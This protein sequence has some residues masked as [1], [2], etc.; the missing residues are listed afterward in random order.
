MN[1]LWMQ[2]I[3]SFE[4]I[5]QDASSRRLFLKM[6]EMSKAGTIGNF[7]AHLADDDEVDEDTKG[8]VA[9]IAQDHAFLLA[10]EDYLQRTHRIH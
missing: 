9:E 1:G 2:D 7:L 5:C 10:V 4:Q 8:S 3:E 6:A